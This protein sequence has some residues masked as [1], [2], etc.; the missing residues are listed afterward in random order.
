VGVSN[1]SAGLVCDHDQTA[2]EPEVETTIRRRRVIRLMALESAASTHP[3]FV[4]AINEDAVLDRREIGLWAVADGVGGAH[5]GDRASQ[6]IVDS[7]AELPAAAS[8]P[9]MLQQLQRTLEQVN[10][11]LYGEALAA[12]SERPIASTVV[13]LLIQG[14]RFFCLW[15]GDSRLYRLRDRRFEQISR[16]HSEVQSLL[17]YG[18]ITADEARRHPRANAITRAIGA[19][20]ELALDCIMG[21]V[22]P[23]DHFLLCSDG[24][25]KVVDDAEIALVLEECTP[26]AAAD[27]LIGMTLERGAPDNVSVATV[28]TVATSRASC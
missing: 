22:E 8:G 14:D 3:G 26:A 15:A 2:A 5:A 1:V 20:Q 9:E 12:G 21:D 27:R 18:L 23:G 25:T 6:A 7:L 19:Q 28:A 10:G 16:D 17:D 4:R 13:C 24:L 11:R